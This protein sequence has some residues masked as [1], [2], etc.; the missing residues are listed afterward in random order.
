[1]MEEGKGNPGWN[2]EAA[3]QFYQLCL[4]AGIDMRTR[5]ISHVNSVTDVFRALLDLPADV[6]ITHASIEGRHP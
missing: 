3:M 1:M 2:P 4:A 5:P 6:R